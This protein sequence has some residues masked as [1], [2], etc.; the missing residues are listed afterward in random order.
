MR[1][2]IQNNAKAQMVSS[3]LNATG[4]RGRCFTFW[5]HMEDPRVGRLSILA[6]DEKKPPTILWT[7]KGFQGKGWKQAQINVIRSDVFKLIIEGVLP[8]TSSAFIGI[9]D[10]V[11]EEGPCKPTLACDFEQGP[12]GWMMDG[13]SIVSAMSTKIPPADHTT[14]TNNGE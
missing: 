12:C 2:L 9:D 8:S 14:G 10:I 5:Y 3:K 1:N 6:S 4:A 7:R 11:L 13:W